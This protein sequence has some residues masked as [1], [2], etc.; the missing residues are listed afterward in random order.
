M[1]DASAAG[2]QAR[3]RAEDDQAGDGHPER[4]NLLLSGLGGSGTAELVAE[5]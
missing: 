1:T 4:S 3:N 2:G 5:G